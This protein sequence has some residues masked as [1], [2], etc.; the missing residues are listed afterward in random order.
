M[1]V[2]RTEV[3]DKRLETFLEGLKV[4]LATAYKNGFTLEA[5]EGGRYIKLIVGTPQKSAYGFIDKINGDVLKTASWNAPAKHARGNI[6]NGDNGLHCCQPYSIEYR[7]PGRPAQSK[8]PKVI[9]EPPIVL[10]EPDDF[11]EYVAKR[12]KELKK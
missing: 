5:V 8:T 12:L 4:I 6:F 7:Q 9:K 11:D 3:F 10:D 1:V 2:K